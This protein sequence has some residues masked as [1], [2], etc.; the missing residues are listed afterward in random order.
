[1]LSQYVDPS[2]SWGWLY[3][4]FGNKMQHP[5]VCNAPNAAHEMQLIALRKFVDGKPQL[6]TAKR[7]CLQQY[8][9]VMRM[10]STRQLQPTLRGR[11][12]AQQTL[13]GLGSPFRR[14][15]D[16]VKHI[17]ASLSLLCPHCLPQERGGCDWH[18]KQ[19][20]G[21]S[22]ST[23]IFGLRLSYAKNNWHQLIRKSFIGSEVN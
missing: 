17:A 18:E 12:A 9:C 4:Q 3:Q 1:M 19:I 6:F 11:S 16:V 2:N 14:A 8:L 21:I 22:V 13:Q 7:R 23:Q 15:G 20:W 10:G 5:T